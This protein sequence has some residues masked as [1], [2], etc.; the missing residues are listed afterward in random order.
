MCIH[1]PPTCYLFSV[2]F[3]SLHTC[4]LYI[5]IFTRVLRP[6]AFSEPQ[7]GGMRQTFS[8]LC[9]LGGMT[10]FNTVPLLPSSASI[11]NGLADFR[12][13]DNFSQFFSHDSAENCSSELPK[14]G[15]DASQWDLNLSRHKFSS[16]NKVR[17]V[18]SKNRKKAK[19]SRLC[20]L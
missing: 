1:D 3:F 14:T 8:C 17:Q 9:R 10:N 18:Y 13:F 19:N 20:P 6:C 4:G 7:V 16:K 15:K 11:F 12:K 2:P 5:A